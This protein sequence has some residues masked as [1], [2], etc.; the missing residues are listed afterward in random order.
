MCLIFLHG[1]HGVSCTFI[2][3][4]TQSAL[5]AAPGTFSL[6]LWRPQK[7]GNDFRGQ[8]AGVHST[9]KYKGSPPD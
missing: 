6:L 5:I 4:Q 1:L 9:N 3:K 8:Q 2:F 7:M